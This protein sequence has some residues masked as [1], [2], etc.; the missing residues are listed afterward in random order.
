[1]FVEILR[2]MQSFSSRTVEENG[3]ERVERN[4]KFSL[5]GTQNCVV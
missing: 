1:M 2:K 4:E 5:E 3:R